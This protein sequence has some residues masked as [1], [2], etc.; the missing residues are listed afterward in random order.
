MNSKEIIIYGRVVDLARRYGWETISDNYSLGSEMEFRDPVRDYSWKILMKQQFTL[1][2]KGV[3]RVKTHFDGL[4]YKIS[5]TY[6]GCESIMTSTCPLGHSFAFHPDK[7]GHCQN[8]TSCVV[9]AALNDASARG[10]IPI[11]CDGIYGV[12]RCS[13]R[14]YTWRMTV[15][16]YTTRFDSF[17]KYKA[18]LEKAK[19]KPYYFVDATTKSYALCWCGAVVSLFPGSVLGGK[20]KLEENCPTCISLGTTTSQTEHQ[21]SIEAYVSKKGGTILSGRY[22]TCETKFVVM[23]G[24]E[25]CKHIWNINLSTIRNEYWCT[26]CSNG[27]TRAKTNFYKVLEDEGY[28]ALGEYTTSTGKVAVKC[29][30]GHFVQVTPSSILS[31]RRCIK[32]CGHCPEEAALSLEIAVGLRG[33]TIIGAYEGS[34]SKVTIDCGKGHTFKSLPRGIKQGN[35]CCHCSASAGELLIM[36]IL[37]ALGI[38]YNFEDPHPIRTR[39]KYDF[40]FE[41]HDMKHIIEVDGAQHFRYITSMDESFE[42]FVTRR[43]RDRYKFHTAIEDACCFLRIDDKTLTDPVRC[44]ELVKEFLASMYQVVFSKPEKYT[45]LYD[46]DEDLSLRK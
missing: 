11:A 26:L 30:K 6:S 31:G 9:C 45:W 21:A 10:W 20:I 22:I 43:D 27:V 3:D 38:V 2:F 42:D 36:K 17:A 33:G 19:M 18:I 8:Q 5:G 34:N 29:P 23:C 41:Y 1:A 32:C 15:A 13:E 4:D 39:L 14:G 12:F 44:A 24:D 25:R 40:S 16:Y 35:W 28:E 46:T 37:D 7:I